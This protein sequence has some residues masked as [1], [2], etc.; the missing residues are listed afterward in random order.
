MTRKRFS[1]FG[2]F[3]CLRAEKPLFP[4]PVRN[5]LSPSFS[6]TSI[7]SLWV[8][9]F[10]QFDNVLVEFLPYFYCACAETDIFE[11]PATILT[12]PCR[13]IR[14]P[15]FPA[16][17]DISA[18]G[19]HFAFYRQKCAIFLLPV[20]LTYICKSG[21]HVPLLKGIIST[22]F[23]AD[24]TILYRVMKLLLPIYY[25][26][27]CPWWLIFWPWTVVVNFSSRCLTLHQ[28]WASYGDPFLS[29]YVHNLTTSIN[30]VIAYW[31]LRMR[32]ITWLFV[33]G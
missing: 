26:T 6:A 3:L 12:M 23:E 20:Y 29:Y 25:V 10:W 8:W 15:R 16:D 32:N 9:K 1:R 7:S 31:P 5:L 4:L 19:I 14:W 17:G 22:K 11:L 2:H 18:I 21:S 27:L 33:R 24:P 30:R 13:W 28:L